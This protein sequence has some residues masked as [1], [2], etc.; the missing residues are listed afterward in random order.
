MGGGGGEWGGVEGEG[1]TSSEFAFGQKP[2]TCVQLGHR[3][4]LG[5]VI[6]AEL[7]FCSKS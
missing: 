5:A 4:S 3:G 7:A 6:S 2:Q 1:I